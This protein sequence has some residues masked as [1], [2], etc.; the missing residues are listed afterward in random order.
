MRFTWL[1]FWLVVLLL[2]LI[3]QAIWLATHVD[4]Y[5]RPI[6]E[7]AVHTNHASLRSSG[8][9][10]LAFGLAAI[11]CFLTNLTYLVRRRLLT[12]RLGTL[13]SWLGFHVATGLLGAGCVV[14]HSAAGLRSASGTMAAV[15][16]FVVVLSGLMG[17]YFYT[18]VPRTLEGRELR[19]SEGRERLESLAAEL[20]QVD[21]ALTLPE[22]T[23]PTRPS[24]LR[25]LTTLLRGDP[26]WDRSL[27]EAT[28]QLRLSGEALEHR[29]A[30]DALRSL[31]REGRWL[32]CLREVQA[33]M[34]TWRFLHRWLAL[35]MLGTVVFH[36]LL[37]ARW[38]ELSWFEVRP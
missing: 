26:A 10:G 8:A 28:A 32:A 27:A 16:L 9:V 34:T 17:R 19:F 36:I 29:R 14:L 31:R 37:A 7:Q 22:P 12:W 11:A 25:L 5:F 6:H 38:G 23:L 24:P 2:G 21:V 33:L 20:K 15:A 35:V 4:Y 1:R 13:R 18:L 3:A 30:L